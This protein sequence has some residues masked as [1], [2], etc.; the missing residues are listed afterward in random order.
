MDLSYFFP[1]K[2]TFFSLLW[3]IFL[4][5][6]LAY[7]VINVYLYT[8]GLTYEIDCKTHDKCFKIKKLGQETMQMP[9]DVDNS[10][11]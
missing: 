5:Y 2:L 6:L 7:I 8:Q 11:L 3:Y 10:T 4:F 9:E 1:T